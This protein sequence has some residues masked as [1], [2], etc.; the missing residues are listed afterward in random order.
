MKEVREQEKTSLVVRPP[1]HPS[2]SSKLFQN[3][4]STELLPLYNIASQPLKQLRRFKFELM[5]IVH[6]LIGYKHPH[7]PNH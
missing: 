7:K 6:R 3:T 4:S 1:T 2:N 5:T